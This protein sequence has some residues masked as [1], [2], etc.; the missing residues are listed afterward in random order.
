MHCLQALT[1]GSQV[2]HFL[3]SF[4]TFPLF[5]SFPPP[6]LPH[7]LTKLFV[8][9]PILL[10][11]AESTIPVQDNSVDSVNG[12]STYL[13]FLQPAQQWRSKPSSVFAAAHS[14]QTFFRHLFLFS[15]GMTWSRLC[16][17]FFLL[18]RDSSSGLFPSLSSHSSSFW[19]LG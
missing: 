6:L 13:A 11:A 15:H 9:L 17:N 1:T 8:P 19:F 3:C 10:V 14:Q 5:L 7:S 12:C 16:S 2:T 18:S 4:Y